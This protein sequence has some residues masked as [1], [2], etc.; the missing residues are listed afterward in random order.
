M[1]GERRLHGAEV[2]CNAEEGGNR[3]PGQTNGAYPR[4]RILQPVPGRFV[5]GGG[6]SVRLQQNVVIETDHRAS[7]PSI[8]SSSSATLSYDNPRLSPS[9]RDLIRNGEAST[10]VVDDRPI[11]NASFTVSLKLFPDR[12]IS[13]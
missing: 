1:F 3:Q 11:L 6:R 2:G 9:G 8:C 7:V 5:M 12:C 10:T 4:D 13:S